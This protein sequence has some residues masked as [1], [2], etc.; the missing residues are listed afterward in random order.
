MADRLDVGTLGH[1]HP[2]W[3]IMAR[4]EGTAPPAWHARPWPGGDCAPW[5]IETGSAGALDALL[6]EI[7]GQ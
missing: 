5:V 6:Y 4:Q 1:R 7:D 2:A 3:Q